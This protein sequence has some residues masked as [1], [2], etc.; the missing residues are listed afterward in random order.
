MRRLLLLA[1]AAAL[2]SCSGK[3]EEKTPP[4]LKRAVETL[5]LKQPCARVIPEH[6]SPSWPV[7][8]ASKKDGDF[9]LMY[10]PVE[11]RDGRLMIGVPQGRAL[12][13]ANGAVAECVR[14]PGKARMLAPL[15]TSAK[16]SGRTREE[17]KA[18]R[19][20][21]YELSDEAGKL[22]SSRKP[23]TAEQKAL[24]REYGQLFT[25]LADPPLLP[26]YYGLE[27]GF[28]D[29]LKAAGAPSISSRG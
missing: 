6:W 11:R 3:K 5:Y 21:L 22:F 7:P 29:W 27:P 2:C 4:R 8:A 14:E 18:R 15:K 19:D 26:Y 28:W 20:R 9:R 24:L 16:A 1:L 13:S 23:P 17:N 12:F 10:Y 25:E